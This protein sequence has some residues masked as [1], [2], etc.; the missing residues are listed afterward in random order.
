M[1]NYRKR[2]SGRARGREGERG[3]KVEGD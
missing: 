3:G 2:E 1:K